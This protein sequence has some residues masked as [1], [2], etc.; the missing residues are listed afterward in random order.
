LQTPERRTFTYCKPLLVEEGKPPREL[1]RLDSKNWTP[2]PE[3]VSAELAHSIE[4]LAK[5]V[6][7]II[8]LDQVDIAETGV[9]TRAVMDTIRHISHSHPQLLIIADSRRGLRA[10]PPVTFKMNAAELAK[11]AG[12]TS[13]LA[14]DAVRRE[15][16]TLARKNARAVFVTMAAE[17]ILGAS[18]SGEI[19]HVPALPVRGEI[20]V[21][22]A[23][24]AVTANLT[25]A[26]AAGA[27]LREAVELAN[28]AGSIVIHQLGTTG[29]ASIEQLKSILLSPAST[30]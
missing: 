16:A 3:K 8:V 25:C 6:D 22:G 28:A 10:F 17:G 27:S 18:P 21:V 13:A 20:D 14:L 2:T 26:L 29:T 7:A 30:G 15:A 1:N 23:G 4:A 11:L 24:D 12:K 9:I 19:E 5:K